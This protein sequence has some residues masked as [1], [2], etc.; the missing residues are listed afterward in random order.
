[1]TNTCARSRRGRHREA[2]NAKGALI[3]LLGSGFPQSY[4]ILEQGMENIIL[5]GDW[6]STRNGNT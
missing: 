6:S 2:T 4:Y 3:A 1:M 5:I